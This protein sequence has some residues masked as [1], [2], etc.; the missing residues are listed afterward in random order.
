MAQPGHALPW[1]WVQAATENTEFKLL[2]FEK[3]AAAAPPHAVLASNTS[4][5]SITK[6]AAVTDRPEQVPCP[7]GPG[8]P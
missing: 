2:L 1:L 4:S 6:I 8:C 7:H 3:I 5:I